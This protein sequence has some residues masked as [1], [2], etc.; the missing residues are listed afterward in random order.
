MGQT[1]NTLLIDRII[2]AAENNDKN[3]IKSLIKLALREDAWGE[4]AKAALKRMGVEV[5][6]ASA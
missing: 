6:N 1:M 2:S 3:A 5:Q 4:Q